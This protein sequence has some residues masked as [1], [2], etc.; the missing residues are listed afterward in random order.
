M[1]EFSIGNNS[2]INV[3]T[4]T[5]NKRSHLFSII[6]PP[7]EPHLS[8]Y[9][10]KLKDRHYMESLKNKQGQNKGEKFQITR[11]S[12][13]ITAS[14]TELSACCSLRIIDAVASCA[15]PAPIMDMIL[16]P[17]KIETTAKGKLSP[18]VQLR[19]TKRT[20]KPPR[21]ITTKFENP[22]KRVT[23]LTVF[24]FES[25]I[26]LSEKKF[27]MTPLL[28]LRFKGFFS[29]AKESGRLDREKEGLE[30]GNG[31]SNA[32]FSFILMTFR[33]G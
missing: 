33:H 30:K 13:R 6:S 15:I 18:P 21:E 8:K 25:L 28:L 10:L 26:S 24:S 27:P 31:A 7:T 1:H 9:Y 5:L 3:Q 23:H 16:M 20:N 4:N 2:P 19:K 17:A 11:L 14:A 22:K 32:C 12:W 29:E